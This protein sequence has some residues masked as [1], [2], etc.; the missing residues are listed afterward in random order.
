MDGGFLTRYG[1]S[2]PAREDLAETAL[3]AFTLLHYPGRIPPVDSRD[4]RNTVPNRM[5]YIQNLLPTDMPLHYSIE[6][7]IPCSP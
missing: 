2:S 3:F 6:E 4:I 7:P 1:Q 5:A